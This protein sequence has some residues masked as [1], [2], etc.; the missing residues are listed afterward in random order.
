LGRNGIAKEEYENQIFGYLGDSIDSVDFLGKLSGREKNAIVGN[1]FLGIINPSGETENCPLSALDFQSL[2]VPVISAKK[3]G[4][5]DTVE[6]SQTGILYNDI[7]ELPGLIRDL[8]ASPGVRAFLSSN[9][10]KYVERKFNFKNIVEEWDK[11]FHELLL[12]E[13]VCVSFSEVRSILEFTTLLSGKIRYQ[14]HFLYKLPT[15]GELRLQ[16]SRFRNSLKSLKK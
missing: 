13:R 4:V 5:I 16:A 9:C 15:F 11:T 12:K 14:F 8:A 2:G 7:Q 3:Y 1:A 6:N 10:V